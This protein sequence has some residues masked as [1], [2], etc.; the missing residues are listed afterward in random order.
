MVKKIIIVVF[1]AAIVAGISFP[2]WASCDMKYQAC[3]V[4]C[5]L[6]HLD[7]DFETA[8]CRGGCV[9]KKIACFSSQSIA[10]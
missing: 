10:R 8:A 6:R 9:S 3:L 1:L 4:S 7:S 5:N 2:Y